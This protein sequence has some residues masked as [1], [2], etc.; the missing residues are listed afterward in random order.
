[1]SVSAEITD[2]SFS[3]EERT[4]IHTE[5]S[6]IVTESV[7]GLPDRD[8]LPAELAEREINGVFV[9]LKRGNTLR[10]C[11]GVHNAQFTIRDALKRAAIAATRDRRM[12]PV[13]EDELKYL[14]LSVSLLD[15]PRR[16]SIQN[17]EDLNA[18]EIGRHG[19]RI[20][21]GDRAGL[22]LPSVARE[23]QWNAMQFLEAV[24]TKA[25]LPSGS[26]QR[27]DANLWVFSGVDFDGQL[28]RETGRGTH[29]VTQSSV[30]APA[31]ADRFYPGDDTARNQLVDNIFQSLS[32]AD[33]EAGKS[34]VA[35][36]MVPHAGLQYSGHIAASVWQRIKLPS[37]VIII[38]PKHTKPGANW[39]VSPCSHW[40]LSESTSMTGAADMAKQLASEVAGMELDDLA[41]KNE[42]GIEVQLPVLYR[43]NPAVRIV[44]ITMGSGTLKQLHVAANSMARWLER[45]PEQP[46]LVISSDMNHFANEPET[47]RKDRLA[48]EQLKANDAETLLKVC[49]SES[50]SMCGRLPAAFVLMTLQCLGMKTDFEEV[51]YATSAEVNGNKDRV[52]GYAGV[53]F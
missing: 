23:R 8:L 18:I 30:R 16:L 5:A 35:A 9:S 46:L 4:A 7:R 44:G 17:A 19:L 50:I 53:V 21:I 38:G 40:Q 36:A 31:V 13:S 32:N 15:A 1:M 42:H 12:V 34:E 48:L 24:C 51:A 37:T 22:L 20:Q 29:K 47:R 10:G 25:Q 39:A 43:I 6:R 33:K 26:W 28:I 41:H 2:V 14:N 11:C 45:Q 27:K 52:V 3:K 49:Q